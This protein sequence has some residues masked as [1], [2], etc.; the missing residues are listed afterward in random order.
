MGTFTGAISMS[1][2]RILALAFTAAWCAPVSAQGVCDGV[3]QVPTTSLTRVTVASGMT[4][5]TSGPLFVTAPPGDT[6]RIFIV[7]QSGII[8]Q[9]VRGAPP[10]T[11]TVFLD[12]DA[13]VN[14]AADEQGLLGLAFHPSF[15]TNGLF[16]VNYTRNVDGDT[17]VSEFKTLDGTGNTAG[18]PASER[19]LFRVVQP[20]DNHNGGWMQF[21]PD[22]FLY[23]ALGDGGGVGDAHGTCGNGQ[24]MQ[25][26]LG[27]M[28][29]IDPTGVE[30]TAPDCG[31]DDGTYSI[32]PGNPFADGAGGDCDE[33][34]FSGLRNPWRSSF[35]AGNGD[36]YVGDVGQGC[37]EEVT[38][39]PAGTSGQNLGWR[40]FEGR[41]CYNPAQGCNPTTSPAN[42]CAP[43]C[44]D[45]PEAD[46]T[47]NG[48]TLPI[49]DYSSLSPPSCAVTG[50][51]VYRGCRMP[52]FQG[53]YFYGDYCA[54]TV[55]SFVQAGGVA[56]NHQDWT[57]QLGTNLAFDLTSFGTDAQGE[58]YITDRDGLVYMVVPPLP[59]FEVSG[60]GAVPFLPDKV[61]DWTWE[62][63]AYTS[64]HTITSYHVLR[65]DVA[66]GVFNLG[67]IF[68]CVF[69]STTPVWPG[70][71]ATNPLP[72]G[73]FAYV[74]TGLNG[75]LQS[76]PGGTPTRTLS[77]N[78]CP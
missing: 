69:Q 63:L 22:G 56:T 66:D 37:W 12:I 70:G 34:W 16:Y 73:M 77:S 36:L 60:K 26:L 27:K 74:V 72:G 33:I 42:G 38:R 40:Q 51:Y 52:A 29:R 64:R 59:A 62:D 48:T 46:P 3:S 67:E 65:A 47:P 4:A 6:G 57:T 54:G 18:D 50:G 8:R 28:L 35:D 5:G 21:G 68:E 71:D 2:R 31:L 1:M 55:L 75:L 49:W 25:T 17:I 10:A 39:L 15:A 78:A 53:T 11:H 45:T 14:N 19:I 76:S 43:A 58:L 20:E 24:N 41:H 30:G 44:A 61:G 13:R 7:L 32:P 9:H 23:T